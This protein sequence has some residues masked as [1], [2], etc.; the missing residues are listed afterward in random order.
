[1]ST[2]LHEAAGLTA[3][4]IVM[5]A[6]RITTEGGGKTAREGEGT[7]FVVVGMILVGPIGGEMRHLSLR[8]ILIL[9][10]TVVRRGTPTSNPEET[11]EGGGKS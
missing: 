9:L 11:P 10:P 1:M 5:A 7:G 2:T 4:R 3:M 8:E 6:L